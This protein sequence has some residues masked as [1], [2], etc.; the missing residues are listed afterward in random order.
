MIKTLMDLLSIES[1]SGNEAK[2]AEYITNALKPL[3]FKIK[4]DEKGNVYAVRGKAPYVM[5]NAHMDSVKGYST[6]SYKGSWDYE[7]GG[8]SSYDP[9]ARPAKRWYYYTIK[10]DKTTRPIARDVVTKDAAPTSCLNCKDWLQCY[11]YSD[12]VETNNANLDLLE[13]DVIVGE[14]PMACCNPYGKTKKAKTK[15]DKAEEEVDTFT[16][17]YDSKTSKL[18]SNGT[19]PMGGDDKTGIAIAIELAKVMP[20]QSFKFLF[21]VEEE[22]G[23]IGI[24]YAIEHHAKF[25]EDC[26]YSITCD[27]KGSSD[28]C[29]TTGGERN[30]NNYFLAELAK[31]GIVT[32]VPVIL[33]QGSSSDNFYIKRLVSNAVNISAGYHSPHTNSE[34]IIVDE[35]IRTLRWV[36]NF[37]ERTDFCKETTE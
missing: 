3:G 9:L 35:T 23:C 17:S 1:Y 27:R 6:K 24:K 29:V 7:Y 28:I 26:L 15:P 37:I 25:F 33:A 10:G 34:Y 16:L 36:R 4:L 14:I 13:M 20:K 22:I 19:R 21:T 12:P 5:M 2:V 32:G 11:K 18:T 30:V 8:H 31:W